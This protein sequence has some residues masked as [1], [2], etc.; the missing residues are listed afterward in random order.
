[1][2]CEQFGIVYLDVIRTKYDGNVF[3]CVCMCVCVCMYVCVCVLTVL[4]LTRAYKSN[5][6]LVQ[7]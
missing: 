4:V 1:M 3:V 7:E 6:Y 2:N 5:L